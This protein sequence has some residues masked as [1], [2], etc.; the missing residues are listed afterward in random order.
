MN[1]T[2]KHHL[3]KMNRRNTCCCFIHLDAIIAIRNECTFLYA[4]VH[5]KHVADSVKDAYFIE[6]NDTRLQRLET[7]LSLEWN[8]NQIYCGFMLWSH[9][10]NWGLHKMEFSG[11]PGSSN[12][13]LKSS[14]M[15][16]F[17]RHFVFAWNQEKHDIHSTIN[18]ARKTISCPLYLFYSIKK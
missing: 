5:F 15:I 3:W 9:L 13:G 8:V 14:M 1:V 2:R 16:S 4:I 10:R 11:W 17:Q 7:C 18:K 12:P 6:L